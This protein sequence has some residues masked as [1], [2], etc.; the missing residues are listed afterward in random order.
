[1]HIVLFGATGM[2]G[3]AA[4]LEAIDDA[5]VDSI[6]VVTRRPTGTRHPKVTELVHDDFADF[7]S[8]EPQLECLDACLYCLGISAAGLSED[9]YRRITRD[10]AVA[11][12]ESM[13]RASPG[14]RMVFISGAGA[15]AGS[16]T[17]WRRVKAEAEQAVLALPW[18]SA[19]CL[20]PAMIMPRRG[21]TSRTRAYRIGYNALGWAYPVFKAVAP[22]STTTSDQLGRAMLAIA[23]DGHDKPILEGADINAVTA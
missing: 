7:S 18:R 9:E 16:G 4:L 6:R 12:S 13:L 2:L 8:L 5:S 14:M 21:V 20:R 10:F 11:A 17:M 22:G 3:Q 15:Q 1:M 19:H 23:R